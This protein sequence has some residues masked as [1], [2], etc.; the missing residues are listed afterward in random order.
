[1]LKM[2]L[3]FRPHPRGFDSS[4]VPTPGNLPS[5]AKKMLMP[6]GQPGVGGGGMGTGGIDWCI[7]V[8][9]EKVT[10]CKDPIFG[11][12]Q[13]INKEC[14]PVLNTF[15]TKRNHLREFVILGEILLLI[16]KYVE[17]YLVS[18]IWKDGKGQKCYCYEQHKVTQ[19]TYNFTVVIDDL[20]VPSIWEYFCMNGSIFAAP[21]IYSWLFLYSVERWWSDGHL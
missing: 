20:E 16:I 18:D 21:V 10:G 14:I 19:F 13:I 17:E 5:K 2:A 3:F 9:P 12:I 4:Q 11:F 15:N 7:N 1:M 6:R 8:E